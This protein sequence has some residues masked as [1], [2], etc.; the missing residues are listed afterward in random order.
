[1]VLFQH[2]FSNFSTPR[3][4]DF[5]FHNTIVCCTVCV[6]SVQRHHQGLKRLGC[7][8]PGCHQQAWLLSPAAAA[9]GLQSERERAVKDPQSFFKV[10]QRRPFPIWGVVQLAKK[11]GIM[12]N[13]D[14]LKANTAMKT[15]FQLSAM[16]DKVN[17][18]WTG[19]LIA[20]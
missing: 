20:Q 11:E 2:N 9:S 16:L 8:V 5:Q 4:A 1:M 10:L 3:R 17:V 19:F 7:C 15:E 6:F 13:P 12:A 14:P 18:C